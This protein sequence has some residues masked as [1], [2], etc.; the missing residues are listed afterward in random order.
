MYH[1]PA[2]ARTWEAKARKRGKTG[3][4]SAIA[5]SLVLDVATD[6]GVAD[7][8][9]AAGTEEISEGGQAEIRAP[10]REVIKAQ[11]RAVALHLTISRPEPTLRGGWQAS[12]GLRRRGDSLGDLFPPFRIIVYRVREIRFAK[13]QVNEWDIEVRGGGFEFA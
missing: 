2:V 12:F 1:H 6:D 8:G 5:Q 7:V 13:V 9:T 11:T 4:K 3:I 10:E